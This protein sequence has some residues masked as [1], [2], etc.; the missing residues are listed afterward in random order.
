MHKRKRSKEKAFTSGTLNLSRI[1]QAQEGKLL[2]LAILQRKPSYLFL[3]TCWSFSLPSSR[4]R[5]RARQRR[6]AGRFSVGGDG[7]RRRGQVAQAWWCMAAPEAGF[8]SAPVQP[9]CSG[10]CRRR[11][12]QG[13]SGDGQGS[14][15]GERFPAAL[16]QTSM[17]AKQRRS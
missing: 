17:C 12:E 7:R 9:Q 11:P 13:G 15:G 14:R 10:P 4:G 3:F 8:G 16:D 5:S 6:G 2:S 1:K